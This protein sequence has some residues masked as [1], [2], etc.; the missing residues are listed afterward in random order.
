MGIPQDIEKDKIHY[1]KKF[2]DKGFDEYN[3]IDSVIVFANYVISKEINT[4]I[5]GI[6]PE[7]DIENMKSKWIIPSLS[8]ALYFSLFY[9]DKN[10]AMYRRCEHCGSYFIVNRSSSTKR[11]CDSYCRN[12]AQQAKHRIKNKQK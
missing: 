9:L 4:G 11:Y 3:M 1:Y 5:E 2:N 6:K 7:C 12:N 8:N 10:K